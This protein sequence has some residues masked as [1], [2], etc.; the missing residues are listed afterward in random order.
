MVDKPNLWVF[1]DSFSAPFSHFKNRIW[2]HK[3]ISYLG[4]H[5]S[6]YGELLA[7]EM[8][9]TLKNQSEPGIGN[10]S[11][12][13]RICINLHNIQKNDIIVIGWSS[14]T[15]WRIVKDEDWLDI[16]SSVSDDTNLSNTTIEEIGI[17]RL[18]KLYESELFNRAELVNKALGSPNTFTY[19]W[20]WYPIQPYNLIH[21]IR[22]E[23][24]KD[25]TNGELIDN[26]FSAKSHKVLSKKIIKEYELW[27]TINESNPF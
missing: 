21:R 1:G 13:D 6:C 12:L 14:P 7:K 11:I 22:G 9:L 26:H 27:K 16:T 24:I 23:R 2:S 15:R 19:H 18:E 3:Y 20:T 5:P 8:N 4:Y 25:A 17:N 10:D